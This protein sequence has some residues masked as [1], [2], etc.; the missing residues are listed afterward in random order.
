MPASTI[1]VGATV[2]GARCCN[3]FSKV[4][5]SQTWLAKTSLRLGNPLASSTKARVTNGQ[6]E[7]CAKRSASLQSWC[8]SPEEN[9]KL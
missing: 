6:S 5:G 4:L 8:W 1:T 9:E 7:R 2:P 3:I